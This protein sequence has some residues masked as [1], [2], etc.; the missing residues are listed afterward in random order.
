MEVALG[1][2]LTL[3]TV[4]T[5][6]CKTIISSNMYERLGLKYTPAEDANFGTYSVPGTGQ[7]NPYA[8]VIQDRIIL[9]L[10]ADVK[11]AV[12]GLRIIHHPT[13]L[14]L[15]GSDILYGGRPSGMW[16]FNGVH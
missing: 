5:G 15:L 2:V 4:D 12:T 6:S 7:I 1:N 14:M 10:S 16:N 9:Q 3:A 13:C 11:F 8:G